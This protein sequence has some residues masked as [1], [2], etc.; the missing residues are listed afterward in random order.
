MGL[1]GVVKHAYDDKD[2]V[3]VGHVGLG[4]L[5]YLTKGE[6]RGVVALWRWPSRTWL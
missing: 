2:L 1:H 5:N 6:H 3:G 4:S